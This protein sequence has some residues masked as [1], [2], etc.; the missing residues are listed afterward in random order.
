[1]SSLLEPN[2]PADAVAAFVDDTVG[3]LPA[4]AREGDAWV[5]ERKIGPP[6]PLATSTRYSLLRLT[7]GTAEIDIQGTISALATAGPATLPRRDCD[8]AVRGG[9]T[10]GSCM[11]DRRTGLPMQSR[12]EQSLEMHV[13]LTDGG[14]FDQYR[15]TLT[16]IK[17]VPDQIGQAG[18]TKSLPR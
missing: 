11:L 8:V 7:P 9:Y 12:V 10:V 18:E 14:E 13:R 4:G 6:L 17:S 2:S 3:L 15:S 16:T 1:L 5:R